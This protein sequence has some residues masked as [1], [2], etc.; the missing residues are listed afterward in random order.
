H[1][2]TGNPA[3][4]RLSN[5]MRFHQAVTFLPVDDSVA[6]A[7][8]SDTMGY[9]GIYLS[10]HLFN[11][12]ELTSRYTYSTAPDGSPFWE[13]ETAWPDPMCLISAM[14]AV[15]DHLSF[16]TGIYIA[17]VRDLITVAKSVGTAAVLSHDRIR[18]GVGV[19][20]CEEEYL[21]TGQDFRTR[22][23]RLNDMIPALRALWAGGWVEYHGTHYDVPLCQMNPSPTAPIPILCG[24][25]SDAAI[26]RAATLCDGW[27]NTGSVVPDVAFRQVARI[28]GALRV[29]G[30]E[31]KG[32]SVVLA[33]RAMPDLDLYR[34]LEDAGVTDLLCAPW[35]SVR[36][37]ENDTPASVWA[38]RLSATEQFA[39]H[40]IANMS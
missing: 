24:G 31:D 30:N 6:L 33:I 40:V 27:I 28:K 10:D 23:K 13:K 9:A 12:K 17:P 39:E 35:M 14:A 7:A 32:F 38:A 3:D 21:Q 36:A 26:T 11:P 25:E 2:A 1:P 37:G 4:P 19:G 16:T 18:L 5:S 20:W 15:T 22:G 8:A 29:A 34:R